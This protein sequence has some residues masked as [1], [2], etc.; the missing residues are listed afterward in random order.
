MGNG[1]LNPG[2]CYL[3]IGNSHYKHMV[4]DNLYQVPEKWDHS[5]KW[6]APK[7]AFFSPFKADGSANTP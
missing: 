7:P 4:N 3:A 6:L 5:V 1:I 2:N